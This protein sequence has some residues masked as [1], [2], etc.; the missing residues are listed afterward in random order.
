MADLSGPELGRLLHQ[1]QMHNQAAN[2][3]GVLLYD[4]T[5]F[6]QVLEGE[7]GVIEAVFAR[8]LLDCRHTDVQILANGATERRQFK[9]WA[10]GLVNYSLQPDSG[11]HNVWPALAQITD[12]ELWLL[13][14]DFQLHAGLV[15][16]SVQV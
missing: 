7:K 15:R 1:S 14:H 4:G 6:L 11:L 16:C 2:I 3:T 10:M 9:S 8:I 12:T 5:R 13:L